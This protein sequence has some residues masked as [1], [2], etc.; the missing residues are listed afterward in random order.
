MRM[1]SDNN[2]IYPNKQTK[3]NSDDPKVKTGK[4]S[5][6][7]SE[8]G[9]EDLAGVKTESINT[10][11]LTGGNVFSSFYSKISNKKNKEDNTLIKQAK[12]SQLPGKT[13]ETG[14]VENK[15]GSNKEM[16]VK[17]T[18][19]R[20]YAADIQ[21]AISTNDISHVQM[22]MMEAKK[23][24]RLKEMA[25]QN[26]AT[27]SLNKKLIFG[28][29]G[30]LACGLLVFVGATI[31]RKM[32]A[33]NQNVST[34]LIPQSMP[35]IIVYDKIVQPIEMTNDWGL[36]ALTNH[37]NS[38]KRNERFNADERITFI[39][40]CLANGGEACQ[41]Q[42]LITTQQFFRILRTAASESLI[43]SFGSQMMFGLFNNYNN[44]TPFLLLPVNSYGQAWS[45]MLEWE[46]QMVY[47]LGSLF[48]T[49]AEALGGSNLTNLALLNLQFRE[50]K[51]DNNDI[52]ILLSAEG[53][54][55]IYYSFIY[56]DHY[57][58][59]ARDRQVLGEIVNRLIVR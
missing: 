17:V 48:F 9:T 50:S 14:Y 32:V 44:V 18:P 12:S 45:G 11:I 30:L 25:E 28:T 27:S 46:K 41:P 16:D 36:N 3:T 47:D 20:T 53:R 57:L 40:F 22:V 42:H 39:P 26:K 2:I 59:I 56:N 1:T 21:S 54:P 33:L 51:Q 31:A 29:V 5:R 37:I 24:E 8:S 52:R 55:L 15:F 7:D 58:L 49:N 6:V 19:I 10:K 34:T 38:I 43:S 35:S 23:Q 4:K 13:N